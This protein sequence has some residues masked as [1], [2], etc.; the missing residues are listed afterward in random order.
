ML[1][2]ELR[3]RQATDIARVYK[4]GSYGGV[5]GVLS[6]KSLASG[7]PQSRVVIVISK[8]ISKRAVV[9]NRLR[10]RI[11]GELERRWETLKTG[12]DIV[13]TVHSDLSDLPSEALNRHITAGLQK[14]GVL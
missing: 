6:V 11:S 9:R 13:V 14:A 3:L 10:R 2:R 4:K 12:Y 8:K 5:S 1:A 7:R